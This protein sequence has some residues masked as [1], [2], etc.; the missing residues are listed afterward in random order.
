MDKVIVIAG[1][2]ASGKTSISVELAKKLSSEIVSSDSVQVYEGLD[3][4]SA[5]IKE[6]EKENI[7]HHMIDVVSPLKDFSMAEFKKMAEEAINEIIK[8]GKTPI[9]A[10]GTGFYIQSLIRDV[11]LSNEEEDITFRNKLEEEAKKYGNA[12][13]HEKLKNID[14]TSYKNI[15]PNNLRRVIRALEYYKNNNAPISKHNE[16][17]KEKGY[18][19]DVKFFVLSFND[20]E[21]LYERT[22][23]RVDL[24]IKEGLVEEVRALL[25][26]G[27]KKDS[28]AMQAIGYKEVIEYI[29]EKITYEEMINKIKINT[30]HLVKRQYTWFKHQVKDAIWIEVDTLGLN[31]EKILEEIMKHLDNQIN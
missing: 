22:D 8:K 3:I 11:E 1:P 6:E 13:V 27:I 18:K 2:T 28:A 21:K 4:G 5:K 25:E 24:M 9:I 30:R 12:Y 17:E 14:E 23:N 31:K 19:Y 15:H 7:I 26:K 20:R 10:G 29:E 16:V